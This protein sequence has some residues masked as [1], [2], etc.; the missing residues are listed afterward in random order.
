MQIFVIHSFS[1]ILWSSGT[2]SFCNVLLSM[3][4]FLIA[5]P[6][7]GFVYLYQN[8]VAAAFPVFELGCCRPA[9]LHFY[10][11]YTPP[12]G[13]S[14]PVFPLSALSTRENV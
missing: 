11:C 14:M 4:Y 8:M 1:L 3:G 13:Y 6:S 12:L 2:H 10:L 9:P 5:C 7:G